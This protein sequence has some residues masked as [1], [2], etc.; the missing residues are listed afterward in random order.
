VVAPDCGMKYLPRAVAY[1]KMCA[2]VE[3]TG[4]SCGTSLQRVER[5]EIRT[6]SAADSHLSRRGEVG[7]RS[8]GVRISR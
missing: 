7:S 8:E 5:I 2:M 6:K 3:G 1:G 4:R